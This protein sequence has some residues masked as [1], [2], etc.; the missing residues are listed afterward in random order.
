ML[1]VPI[2]TLRT[3]LGVIEALETCCQPSKLS[4]RCRLALS[5]L[6]A[7]GVRR[8]V[9]IAFL[10]ALVATPASAQMEASDPNPPLSAPVGVKRMTRITINGVS[11]S[12]T[13]QTQELT[14]AQ[15]ARLKGSDSG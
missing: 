7:V 2:V 14:D 6:V 13:M 1:H 8:R 4:L 12:P 9:L 11:L 15:L 10:S 5:K 3:P